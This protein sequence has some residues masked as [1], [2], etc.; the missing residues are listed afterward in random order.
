MASQSKDLGTKFAVRISSVTTLLTSLL[1]TEEVFTGKKNK[2]TNPMYNK[3]SI[4]YF[5]IFLFQI[6]VHYIRD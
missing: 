5:I 3:L 1:E 4:F 2:Q 6:L